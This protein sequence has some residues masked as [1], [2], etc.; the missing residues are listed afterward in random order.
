[1]LYSSCAGAAQPVDFS[2]EKAVTLH[3]TRSLQ[4]PPQSLRSKAPRMLTASSPHARAP[5]ASPRRPA[6]A[7]D[8]AM[9]LLSAPHLVRLPAAH[10]PNRRYR[11]FQD[12]SSRVSC[13]PERCS[14]R[15]AP[16]TRDDREF[17]PALR[18][19]EAPVEMLP[20]RSLPHLVGCVKRR[21]LPDK[22]CS[23]TGR[24]A[25]P[26]LLPPRAGALR[27]AQRSRRSPSNL[28]LG[29]GWRSYKYQTQLNKKLLK[30]T[31]T[32]AAFDR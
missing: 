3:S 10:V 26:V 16:A 32:P 6:P 28:E 25:P 5:A 7:H 4:V 31:Q 29:S 23:H 21:R 22:E 20:A 24:P 1:M 12:V 27:H 2:R 19:A 17:R 14:R 15:S 30:F 13:D 11:Q 9:R 18:D 8:A